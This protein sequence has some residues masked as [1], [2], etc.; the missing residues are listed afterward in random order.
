MNEKT[1]HQKVRGL[2]E[3]IWVR[4]VDAVFRPGVL[5]PQI[6]AGGFYGYSFRTT[7]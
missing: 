1:S 6:L 5:I 7:K 2:L 3:K 4:S